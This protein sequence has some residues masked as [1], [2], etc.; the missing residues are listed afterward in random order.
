M[1]T[2]RPTPPPPLVSIVIPTNNRGD[3][4][5]KCIQS[6]YKNTRGFAFETIIV[7]NASAD[8]TREFLQKVG[9][10]V[11]TI[12]NPTNLGFARACNQ[13]A[14]AAR[15][16][17]VLF[18]NNDTEVHP[19]WLGPLVEIAQAD[20]KVGMVGPKLLYPDGTLQHIGVG[21]C[22][23]APTPIQPFHLS[24]GASASSHGLE[25]RDH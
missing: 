5:V 24:K 15:G 18:L 3:L 8:G 22:Y 12:L 21:F 19:G 16:R 2:P 25:A 23:G 11:R 14:A 4:T 17:Y 9:H 20:S 13:G 1:S 7:D 10:I 6:I